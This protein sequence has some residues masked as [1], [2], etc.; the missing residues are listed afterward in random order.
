MKRK[1]ILKR[2]GSQELAVCEQVA[3]K[4]FIELQ[5]NNIMPLPKDFF[6][7]RIDADEHNEE[8]FDEFL[9]VFDNFKDA[10]T[11]FF[12][13]HNFS[14]LKDKIIK[15]ANSGLDVQ[16]HGYYHYTYNDYRSN[17]YNINKAKRFFE[18]LGITTI[19]FAAPMG[20]WNESL[21]YALEDEGYEYSSDFSYDY[22][23]FPTYPN[24]G[25]RVSSILE[26]PIFPVAPELF[27]QNNNFNS[28]RILEFYEN[29]IKEI[30]SCGL[31]VIIYAHTSNYNEI[32]KLL[33]SILEFAILKNKLTPIN[34]TN[35]YNLWKKIHPQKI[36]MTS[37]ADKIKI[38]NSDLLGETINLEIN[39]FLKN[40]FK[41]LID[42]ERITPLDEIQYGWF[43][44]TI[45]KVLR[46]FL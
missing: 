9:S 37:R 2:F 22:L 35:F 44:K 40:Y 12:N 5:G 29:A 20:K 27:F 25:N 42:F 19:G 39:S 1:S 23:G 13:A 33:N 43:K 38:P 17:R 41:N 36:Q 45:N 16:S 7:L 34:L 26:I 32:P 24:L 31:P 18:E 30:S 10:I 28:R 21:M 15:C 4:P 11:I 6:C 14:S 46:N 3:E 8:L